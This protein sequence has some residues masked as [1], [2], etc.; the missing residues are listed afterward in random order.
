MV[1]HSLVQV[2]HSYRKADLSPTGTCSPS[3]RESPAQWG[4][5]VRMGQGGGQKWK[6]T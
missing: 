6:E 1:I 3:L 4:L 2:M 5:G